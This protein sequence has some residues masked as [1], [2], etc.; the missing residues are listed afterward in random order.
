VPSPHDPPFLQSRIDRRGAVFGPV[1]NAEDDGSF[2]GRQGRG[3]EAGRAEV[4]TDIIVDDG[5]NDSARFGWL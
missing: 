1:D 2:L 3:R 5:N 4:R